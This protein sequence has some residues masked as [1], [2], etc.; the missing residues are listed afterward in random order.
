MKN[1]TLL[2]LAIASLLAPPPYVFSFS[3]FDLIIT[4]ERA[5]ELD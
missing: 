1:K 4:A 3:P 2:I 5:A